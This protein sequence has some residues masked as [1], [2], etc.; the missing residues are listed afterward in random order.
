MRIPNS[1]TNNHSI[2]EDDLLTVTEDII[3]IIEN[4]EEWNK[5]YASFVKQQ[6]RKFPYTVQEF[7]SQ[8]RLKC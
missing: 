6:L 2:E 8:R 4:E 5:T 7:L 3:S 1:D